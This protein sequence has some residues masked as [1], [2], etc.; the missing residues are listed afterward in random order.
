[1]KKVILPALTVGIV[2]LA[3]SYAALYMLI[4]LMPS[5]VEEYYNPIFYPGADRAIL[6]YVHPFILGGALSWMWNRFK[7]QFR[8][9]GALRGLE[10]G[11][12][13]VLVATLPS[14]WITFS[15]ISVSIMM[16]FS[17][18]AYG[19]IQATVAGLIFSRMNP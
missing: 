3:L 15:A 4:N 7:P 1:M 8:A 9:S 13:Y 11:L 18:L 12:I 16:V 5:L 10:F 6:F 2:L 14:M 19:W 17:W